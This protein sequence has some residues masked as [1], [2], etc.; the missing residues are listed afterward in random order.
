ML[1]DGRTITH[2]QTR[3]WD[4]AS[5]TIE[6]SFSGPNGQT[7]STERAW[8]PEE[9][10]QATTSAVA[11]GTGLAPG[12]LGESAAGAEAP[13]KTNWLSKLNPFARWGKSDKADASRP[14]RSGFTLGA[15]RRGGSA[16]GSAGLSDR[17]SGTPSQGN[18]LGQQSRVGRESSDV[19]RGGPG[20]NRGPKPPR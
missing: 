13:K 11:P 6:R 5:G 16:A 17:P 9:Y 10:D 19:A 12:A 2:A 8:S 15:A 4:G 3:T 18:R 1:R 7:R 14:P 20:G